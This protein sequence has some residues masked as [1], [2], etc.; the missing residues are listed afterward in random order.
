MQRRTQAYRYVKVL[1]QLRRLPSPLARPKTLTFTFIRSHSSPRGRECH[2]IRWSRSPAMREMVTSL[3][4]HEKSASVSVASLPVFY[5]SPRRISTTS[6]NSKLTRRCFQTFLST[7][8]NKC[9]A[10]QGI[11]LLQLDD[12]LGGVPAGVRPTLAH[13]CRGG[14]SAYTMSCS[15]GPWRGGAVVEARRVALPC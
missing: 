12:E 15:F 6:A 11:L 14:T 9:L 7:V 3:G 5:H 8:G 10:I 4:C 2:S 1:C 13:E